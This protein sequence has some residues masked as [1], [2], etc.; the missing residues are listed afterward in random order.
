MATHQSMAKKFAAAKQQRAQDWAHLKRAQERIVASIKAGT[1]LMAEHGRNRAIIATY[2]KL[3]GTEY[4]TSIPGKLGLKQPK[5]SHARPLNEVIADKAAR[6][7]FAKAINGGDHT[8]KVM[9]GAKKAI[10]QADKGIA[11]AD[12]TIAKAKA[13]AER[14]SKAK[15]AKALREAHEAIGLA[16]AVCAEIDA[17]AK[18]AVKRQ[19]TAKTEPTM[20][21]KRQKAPKPTKALREATLLANE[22]VLQHGKAPTITITLTLTPSKTLALMAWLQEQGGA[23]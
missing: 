18:V 2:N 8:A 11:R 9:D 13:F 6:A 15:A 22:L 17:K 4:P 7:A 12:K 21:A 16:D 3:Y 19:P 23:Q 10:A 5:G 14:M 20:A 1:Y